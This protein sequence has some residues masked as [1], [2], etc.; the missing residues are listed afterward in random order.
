M[1]KLKEL[2]PGLREGYKLDLQELTGAGVLTFGNI[3]YVS[4]VTGSNTT[5]TGR[6]PD[7]PFATIAAA[8]SAAT[9][10]QGDTIFL[11]PGHAETVSSATAMALSKAGIT[12]IGLGVGSL[13]P[14]I[15]LD[16]I[17]SATIAVS[18]ANIKFYNV[19]FSANFA[20]IVSLF[21]LT[22]A[23]NF[24][25]DYCEFVETAINM[26]FLHI[27]DLAT[28]DNAAD[29]L[30]VTNCLWIE[31][32]A[33]TLAFALIDGN[34]DRLNI[35]D[36]IMYTGNA[37]QDTPFL[38]SCGSKVLTGVRVIR[39]YCQMV[40]NA[41][42]SAGLFIVNSSTT[43]NGLVALNFLKHLTTSGDIIC[44]T[45]TKLAFHNNYL[46]GVADKSG[47]V[48]PAIDA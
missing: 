22:T 43:S 41:S 10:S 25:L 32:D 34:V 11:M 8:V 12:F 33:A 18:A 35:S 29:G 4:S 26:N 21:T 24:T 36:N 17:T 27:I 14:T 16:T 1:A 30:T 45:G 5:G 44:N 38:L 9:S 31:P 3:W 46:T 37:T 39:N 15:T 2:V 20:D 47:Y 28:T 42:S 48:L 19:V 7:S 23:K 13:R 40:G 6:S